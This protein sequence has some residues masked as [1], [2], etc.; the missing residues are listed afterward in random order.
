MFEATG[1]EA[2]N[3]QRCPTAWGNQKPHESRIKRVL[4]HGEDGPAIFAGLEMIQT[5][6]C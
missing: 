4:D 1:C 6:S 3:Q 2:K 5:Q